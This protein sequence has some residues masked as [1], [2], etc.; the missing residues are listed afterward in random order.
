[1]RKAAAG[2]F[3]RSTSFSSSFIS[4]SSAN[5]RDG[6]KSAKDGERKE[7]TRTHLD[8]PFCFNASASLFALSRSACCTN[9]FPH[10]IFAISFSILSLSILACSAF[11]N[12][13]SI[14]LPL[15]SR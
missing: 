12:L 9:P 4:L 3:H 6:E 11:S 5:L 8:I 1:M 13:T 15:A 14:F 7:E 2:S 10:S